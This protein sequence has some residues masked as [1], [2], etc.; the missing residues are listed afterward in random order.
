[1]IIP[2]P[3]QD[4]E[5]ICDEF[6]LVDLRCFNDCKLLLGRNID[7]VFNLAADMGGIGYIKSNHSTIMYNN[8]IITLNVLEAARQCGVKRCV[9]FATQGPEA[10]G[11]CICT[12]IVLFFVCMRI[13]RLQAKE[14]HCGRWW[15]EGTGR[16][17]CTSKEFHFPHGI[18]FTSLLLLTASSYFQPQDAYGLEKLCAEQLHQHYMKSYGLV[19]RIARLHTVYGP[20]NSWKGGREKVLAAFCR[21]VSLHPA[22]LSTAK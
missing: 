2:R 1:M 12:Q 21:K 19:T 15:I 22:E 9:S 4:H 17:A 7:H 11:D 16:L 8:T 5:Q 14:Y 13:P 6:H 18:H 20:E 3:P 10:E